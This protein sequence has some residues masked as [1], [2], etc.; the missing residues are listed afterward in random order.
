[1]EITVE[2]NLRIQGMF[3]PPIN[4]TFDGSHIS[5]LDVLTSLQKM[6]KSIELVNKNNELGDDIDEVFVNEKRHFVSRMPAGC[7]LSD[8]DRVKIEIGFAPLGG[9]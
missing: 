8:G 7:I 3:E 6:C 1:M 2:S 9:G 4:L 5:L